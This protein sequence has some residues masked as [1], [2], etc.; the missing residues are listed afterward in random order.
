[1][2]KEEQ[3]REIVRCGKDPV[4]FIKNYTK[5]HHA[6]RGIIPFETYP[7]QDDCLRQFEDHR[8]NIVLK[9]RQLGLS[10]ICAGYATWFALFHKAKNILIIAN[11]LDTAI[12]FLKK[13]KAIL[14]SVPSWMLL[15][16][17]E[18]NMRSIRLSNGSVI[19]A[20][21]TSDDAGRSE[22]LS[23]L[24]V[25]EAAVIRNFE[26]VWTGLYPTISTGGK[27]IIL[28][29][30][31]GVG[32]QYHKLW[33]DSEAG[34]NDFNPIK[35]PWNVHPEHNEEWFKKETR[36]LA[37]KLISQEFLCDFISSGETFLQASELEYLHTSIESPLEKTGE[38]RNVWIWS[39]PSPGKKYVMSADIARGDGAD[40]STF[41]VIDPDDCSVVAEYKG[42]LP[43]DRFAD[44][45]FEFGMKYNTALICPENN[46]FGYT[47]AVK[48]RD[49][50]YP[51]LY[52]AS[53][54]GG[55]YDY[56]P[57][58]PDEVPG[59]STQA[60]S[61]I[62]ILT[63]LEE[64]IRNKIVK[65]KSQRLYSEMQ[66]FVWTGSKATTKKGSNDD[67]VMSLAIGLWLVDVAFGTGSVDG[68]IKLALLGAISTSAR[69]VNTLLPAKNFGYHGNRSNPAI[70]V[71][72]P[73]KPASD[74]VVKRY[75]GGIDMS[76]WLLK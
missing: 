47:S 7:F 67:L 49:A 33:V 8:F 74:S 51:R 40:C 48:L 19:T 29:T 41:H 61:R 35:L 6:T 13:V 5:I 2:K 9:S 21:P 28:S 38:D 20:I 16:K 55:I 43:P 4:Y 30:P 57:I 17:F 26:E 25:D 45:M 32:G 42:K 15:T 14:Q 24:I 75:Y 36:G 69:S 31:K 70:D 56:K 60:K 54:R 22:A 68:D 34:I 37:T 1:M 59:F 62:Q 50:G 53:A 12:N 39:Y 3:V 76:N 52:Y 65:S 66:T 46:T 10:T 64:L 23:L 63:K 72:N 73:L 44:L 18:M 11:K 27:A 71:K 58:D